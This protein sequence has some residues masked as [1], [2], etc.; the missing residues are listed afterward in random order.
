MAIITQDWITLSWLHLAVSVLTNATVNKMWKEF[1]IT[2]FTQ[3][4]AYPGNWPLNL[5]IVKYGLSLFAYQI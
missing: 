5:L 1:I 4:K 3:V 2:G